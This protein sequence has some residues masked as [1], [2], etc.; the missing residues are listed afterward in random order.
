MLTPARG[1]PGMGFEATAMN[2]ETCGDVSFQWDGVELTDVTTEQNFNLVVPADATP[3]DPSCEGAKASA[4]GR[5]QAAIW[6][7]AAR[8]RSRHRA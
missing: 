7:V 6:R 5:G 2:F 8:V 1:W 3:H 4:A